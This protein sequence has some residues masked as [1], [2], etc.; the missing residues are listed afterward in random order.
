MTSSNPVG[1]SRKTSDAFLQGSQL[2]LPAG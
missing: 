1:P 2:S